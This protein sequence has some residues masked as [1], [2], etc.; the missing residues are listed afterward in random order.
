MSRLHILL[1]IAFFAPALSLSAQMGLRISPLNYENVEKGA[2]TSFIV[3]MDMDISDRTAMAADFGFGFDLY[4]V[5]QTASE[6]YLYDGYQVTVSPITRT[7]ALTLRSMYFLSDMTSGSYIATS[8]GFRTVRLQLDPSVWDPNG[9]F[10]TPLPAWAGSSE[11]KITLTQLGLRFGLRSELEGFYGDLYVGFGV[12]LGELD[13]LLPVYLRSSDWAL[14]RAYVQAGYS[15]G[16]G[17]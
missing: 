4:G 14:S 5:A 16:I 1:V 9:S 6:T 13:G 2:N 7:Q 11:S 17:W 10:G 15:F 8:L 12:N 3:G